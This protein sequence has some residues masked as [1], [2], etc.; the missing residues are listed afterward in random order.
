MYRCR[1]KT[2][3]G[4]RRRI[5]LSDPPHP[6]CSSSSSTTPSGS[7]LR[8]GA[9][10]EEPIVLPHR[11]LIAGHPTPVSVRCMPEIAGVIAA[12]PNSPDGSRNGTA[13]RCSA[14]APV[15][16]RSPASRCPQ[17]RRA[18]RLATLRPLSPEY[19]QGAGPLCAS[20]ATPSYAR[21]PCFAAAPP[22]PRCL[23]KAPVARP[24][25]RSKPLRL[26]PVTW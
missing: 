21:E 15:A 6:W 5:D 26:R 10:C 17:L 20:A 18:R 2:A 13:P 8:M 7:L 11:G 24:L 23:R 4:E 12:F 16:R 14:A 19:H 9:V 1:H 3:E 22:W 25:R